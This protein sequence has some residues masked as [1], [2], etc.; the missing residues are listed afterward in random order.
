[1]T[2]ILALAA[3]LSAQAGIAPPLVEQDVQETDVAYEE[4]AS[5]QTDLAIARIEAQLTDNPDDPALLINL[6]SAWAAKGEFEKAAEFYQRAARSD[7]RYRM[8]LADGNW[9]DSRR[10][11]RLALAKIEDQRLAMR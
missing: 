11:A 1:M 5:G 8:E 3:M 7:V 4:L 10:A 9:V 6:G 2:G